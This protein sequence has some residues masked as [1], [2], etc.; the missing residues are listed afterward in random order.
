MK[1]DSGVIVDG[2]MLRNASTDTFQ[3]SLGQVYATYEDTRGIELSNTKLQSGD[4]CQSQRSFLL[5]I[6]EKDS[7][8][9]ALRPPRAAHR[10]SGASFEHHNRRPSYKAISM[11]SIFTG[12]DIRP[13]SC[14][15]QDRPPVSACPATPT[16]GVRDPT[17]VISFSGAKQKK[18]ARNEPVQPRAVFARKASTSDHRTPPSTEISPEDKSQVMEFRWFKARRIPT[19][20]VDPTPPLRTAKGTRDWYSRGNIL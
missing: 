7:P 3:R 8:P 13:N 18:R 5:L 19:V 16:N 10:R 2:D 20:D 4:N 9:N 1:R 15:S 6:M 17:T 14:E 11:S 12:S